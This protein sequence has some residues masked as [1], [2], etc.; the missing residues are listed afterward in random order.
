[1]RTY[2]TSN[3]GTSWA[4]TNGTMDCHICFFSRNNSD[5][6]LYKVY[7]N[8]TNGQ[9]NW[10]T[11]YNDLIQTD[12]FPPYPPFVYSPNM[13]SS[14]LTNDTL[15]VTY[16]WGGAPSLTTCWLNSTLH[17]NATGALVRNIQNQSIAYVVYNVS[18]I[19]S[20]DWNLGYTIPPGLYYV[21][22]TATS[23]TTG[24]S[25]TEQGVPFYINA[26]WRFVPNLNWTGAVVNYSHWIFM[27][28][29][30]WSGA[31][32]NVTMWRSVGNW[33]GA[34]WNVTFRLFITI[35]GCG[36]VHTFPATW[37]DSD[38]ISIN[39]TPC[40][41]C[42]FDHWGGDLA[43]NANPTTLLMDTDRYITANFSGSIFDYHDNDTTDYWGP[44]ITDILDPGVGLFSWARMFTQAWIWAFG[45][46]FIALFLGV[47][48]GALYIK[49]NS[50]FVSIAY[51]ILIL[52]LYASVTKNIAYVFAVLIALIIGSLLYK[53]I[54]RKNENV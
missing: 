7:A 22:V 53:V 35:E 30:N 49:F 48:A 24:L 16:Y 54:T 46:W 12:D 51:L 52:I 28:N 15:N 45:G 23:T 43:G 27:P 40:I 26:T 9:G 25:S 20:Y 31:V 38:T 44:D 33:S 47:I 14:C 37:G 6:I 3:G 19:F 39:A 4:V 36:F 10:S 41:M 29:L 13:S 34:V 11:I 5:N 21:N 32:W 42:A 8:L 18:Q 50:P 1:M 17:D 2:I